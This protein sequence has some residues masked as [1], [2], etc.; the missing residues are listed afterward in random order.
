[1][2]LDLTGRYDISH[3][4]S[5]PYNP[6]ANG[7]TVRANGIICKI[8][9]KV[10]TF[11]KMDWDRKLTSVVYAYNM[12]HESTA[13]KTPYFLVFRQEAFQAEET[14]VITFRIF[15]CRTRSL[16]QEAASTSGGH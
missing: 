3:R 15:I 4:K 5:S 16:D 12:A 10:V 6:K 14:E 8:L 1:M 13:S 2:V 7:M 9:T 11:H